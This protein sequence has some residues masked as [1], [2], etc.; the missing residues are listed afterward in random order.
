MSPIS[1]VVRA[2]ALFTLAA[3]CG[4]AQNTGGI[5]GSITDAT[6]ASVPGATVSLYLPG[7]STAVATTTTTA[8]GLFTFSNVNPANYDLTIES[9]GFLKLT[10]RS[11]KVD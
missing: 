6:G 11:V 4:F 7:G 5:N 10:N 8:D 1:F 3:L 9:Q 2:T